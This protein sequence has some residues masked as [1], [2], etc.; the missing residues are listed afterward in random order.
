MLQ[1]IPLDQLRL[2]AHNVRKTAAET[3]LD[4]LI[5]SLAH[6]G[7][8]QNLVVI[9][10]A[11]DRFA[12]IAGGRR[13][14]A[15]QAVRQVGDAV[16]NCPDWRI[17]CRIV[18]AADATELSLAE[19]TVRIA[20]HPAD[21][22]EAWSALI[23]DGKTVAEVATRFGVSEQLVRQRL[24]LGRV[25]PVLLAAYRAEKLTL[26]ALKAFALTDDFARQE[27]LWEGLQQY[28][29]SLS[30]HVIRRELTQGAVSSTTR[31]ARFVGAEAYI[32]AGGQI[33]RDLFGETDYFTDAA[34]L[35]ALASAKL[36]AEADA[37]RPL[38]QWVEADLNPDHLHP[39][40]YRTLPQT[41]VDAPEA[42]IQAYAGTRARL[43]QLED[44]TGIT[45]DDDA[46]ALQAEYG[47]LEDEL[48][49]LQDALEPF[50]THTA[51]DRARSGCRVTVGYDGRLH[52]Q[53]GLVEITVADETPTAAPDSSLSPTQTEAGYS[54]S[55]C[56]DLATCRTQ[57]LQRAVAGSFPAALDLLTY[58]LCIQLLAPARQLRPLDLSAMRFAGSLPETETVGKRATSPAALPLDWATGDPAASFAAF[59]ALPEK[60]KQRLLAACVAECLTGGLADTMHPALEAVGRR[61]GVDLR[62]SWQPDGALVFSRIRKAQLLALIGE[63]LDADWQTRLAD[64][65]K[66]AIVRFLD[67]LFR[68]DAT[69][70]AGLSA[71]MLARVR[72]WLPE[73]MAFAEPCSLSADVDTVTPFT[74]PEPLAAAEPLSASVVSLPGWMTAA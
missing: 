16:P 36:A 32:A 38:W 30:P 73:G 62:A 74:C 2:S 18:A 53:A 5:A 57:A 34:L 26:D 72:A 46:H 70:T 43:D 60:D 29:P 1:M 44:G 12:V 24:R 59:C 15:L 41:P 14:R 35:E 27:A 66:G 45:E 10:N 63:L 37:L 21:Q 31:M 67:Q 54:Q 22:F 28:G 58:T 52:I 8:Q 9:Q 17:P 61:L 23:T 6:H 64:Q 71:A 25:S 13:L 68:G 56:R 50:M 48:A 39:A 20:M 51:A 3:A 42:L 40:R 33:T 11:P 69:V 19:N 55:L 4:E 65:P 49:A 7:L 47:Q